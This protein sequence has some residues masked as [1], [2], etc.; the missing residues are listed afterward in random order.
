[1]IELILSD[2]CNGCNQCVAACPTDVLAAGIDG[3]PTIARQADCQ[4]CF[5]CE[6]YCNSDAL[7]VHPASDHAVTVDPEQI[8]ASGLL[9]QYRRD[10]GWHEWADDPR[11]TNQHW[12]M[13]EIFVLARSLS[14]N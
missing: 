6:L 8:R 4:T 12:R 5:M 9:G 11:Y 3:L 1:M 2:R 14:K 7:Y 13:E 10:S